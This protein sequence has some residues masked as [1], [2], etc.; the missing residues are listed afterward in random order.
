MD[1]VAV[2]EKIQILLQ[3]G[4]LRNIDIYQ[5]GLYQIRAR[6]YCKSPKRIG[7]VKRQDGTITRTI[8]RDH[9]V[10]EPEFSSHLRKDQYFVQEVEPKVYS[11]CQRVHSQK[12]G[13]CTWRCKLKYQTPAQPAIAKLLFGSQEKPQ[14]KHI[15]IVPTVF[16]TNAFLLRHQ[17]ETIPL[18]CGGLFEITLDHSNY[19]GKHKECIYVEVSL[20]FAEDENP[21]HLVRKQTRTLRLNRV[22]KDPFHPPLYHPV[23]FD[24]VYC[25]F[26][27]L[28]VT[29]LVSETSIKIGKSISVQ[30]ISEQVSSEQWVTWM[31]TQ[32][33]H[34]DSSD[35]DSASSLMIQEDESSGKF[36]LKSA[37]M[38]AIKSLLLIQKDMP[39]TDYPSKNQWIMTYGSLWTILFPLLFKT[40]HPSVMDIPDHDQQLHKVSRQDPSIPSLFEKTVQDT[41]D[42][43]H[44]TLSKILSQLNQRIQVTWDRYKDIQYNLPF[45]HLEDQRTMSGYKRHTQLLNRIV[46]S[47][48]DQSIYAKRRVLTKLPPSGASPMIQDYPLQIM[49]LVICLTQPQD[50]N[51]ERLKTLKKMNSYQNLPQVARNNFFRHSSYGAKPTTTESTS[52]AMSLRQLIEDAHD[53][54]PEQPVHLIVFVH[55]LLGSSIDLRGYRN[56]IEHMMQLVNLEPKFYHQYLISSVNEKDTMQDIQL[57]GEQLA[58]EIITF[59]ENQFNTIDKISFVCHSLGVLG[60]YQVISRSKCLD[61]LHLLDESDHRQGFMYKLSQ[62]ESL[63]L[64]KNVVL[65]ASKQDLYAP[66]PSAMVQEDKIAHPLASIV[67]E[68]KIHFSKTL[69]K[70]NLYR[71]EIIFPGLDPQTS[72]SLND[73]LGR[74]AHIAM[75]EDQGFLELSSILHHLHLK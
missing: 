72:L 44:Q 21:A 36:K 68:M 13:D 63:L 41:A 56:T 25:S 57:M 17:S 8:G 48:P 16:C 23:T 62:D 52:T 34:Q 38:V 46:N 31:Q 18:Y 29:R 9:L 27:D 73:I 69:A 20:F 60:I 26:C 33:A 32:A 24:S 64:F 50:A 66:F 22:T 3:F 70:T 19:N 35:E 30:N 6:V 51:G 42:L 58:Q 54:D 67:S 55:G 47:R 59:V 4:Q 40:S 10:G 2:Q 43:D 74:K 14:Y 28:I 75:L 11:K 1:T 49:P 5:A 53:R 39:L 7:G 45:K 65:F 15:P 37:L 71:Y 12:I 61:Q